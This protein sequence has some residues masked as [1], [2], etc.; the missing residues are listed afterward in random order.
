MARFEPEILKNIDDNFLTSN[1]NIFVYPTN[2]YR[3]EFNNPTFEHL[4]KWSNSWGFLVTKKPDKYTDGKFYK[5]EEYI[6][7]FLT[8][9]RILMPI[10][11][12]AKQAN[13]NVYI[14]KMDNDP[15][16]WSE[17]IKPGFEKQ[18]DNADNVIFLWEK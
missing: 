13:K 15:V 3:K 9:M 2:L 11:Y 14:F 6:P 7:I 12:K 4:R 18:F 8:Y 16:L 17:I 10:I 5:K 1:K